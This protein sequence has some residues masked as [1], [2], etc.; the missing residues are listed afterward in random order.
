MRFRSDRQNEDFI[1]IFLDELD[2]RNEAWHDL[3]PNG[4]IEERA[5]NDFP[6]RDHK[7]ILHVIRRKWI[8]EDG[9]NQ[10]FELYDLIEY[11]TSYLIN[12]LF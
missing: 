11:K 12:I 3:K 5:I 2:N 10:F 1:H 4:F 9:K 6:I 8:T 7:G